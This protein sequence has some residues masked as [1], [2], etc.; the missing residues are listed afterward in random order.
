MEKQREKLSTG[1]I[2]RA[3]FL[4][5]LSIVLTRFASVMVTQ[6]LRVGIGPFPI[7][8]S[9]LLYGPFVG[10]IVGFVADIVGV[11]INPHGAFHLGF[12][13]SSILTGV[14]PGIV[15]LTMLKGKKENLTLATI[16]AC[17]LVGIIVHIGLDTYWLTLLYNKGAMAMLPA[18]VIKAF[19]QAVISIIVIRALYKA[20]DK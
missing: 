11:M 8:L 6:D 5:A 13:L 12:T 9:G 4:A 19:I 16:V 10:G 2:A 3:A 7:I 1:V 20:I 17:S 14:I 18:R 15:Y